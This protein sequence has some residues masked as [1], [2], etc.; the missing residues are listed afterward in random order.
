[1]KVSYFSRILIIRREINLLVLV[2]DLNFY[3]KLK[4]CRQRNIGGNEN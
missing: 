1:M 3:P 4:S 2:R